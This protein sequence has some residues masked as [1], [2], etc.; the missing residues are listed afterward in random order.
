MFLTELLFAYAAHGA[1][2]GR[3][4]V[5]ARDIT[6]VR[7]LMDRMPASVQQVLLLDASRCQRRLK[8]AE[9]QEQN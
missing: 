4:T 2:A 3:V 1:S 7:A 6:G 5:L 8:A 9:Q